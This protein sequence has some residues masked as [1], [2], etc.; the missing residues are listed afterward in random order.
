MSTVVVRNGPMRL[1]VTDDSIPEAAVGTKCLP[2][3]AWGSAPPHKAGAV[4]GFGYV[5]AMNTGNQVAQTTTFEQ[6][7]SASAQ[8]P[9]TRVPRADFLRA[10]LNRFCPDEHSH[11]DL[12]GRRVPR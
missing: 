6:A 7:L 9:G 1:N 10:E 5:T 3:A 12:R 2:P 8:L 11:R 4:C